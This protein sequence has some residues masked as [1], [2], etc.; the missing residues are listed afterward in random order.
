MGEVAKPLLFEGFHVGGYIVLFGTRRILWYSSFLDNVSKVLKLE[1]ISY[2]M[3]V[4]L[5]LRVSFRVSGFFVA[6]PYLW[7][8]VQFFFFEG[9]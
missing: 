6:L 3:F 5:L 2:E 8:K 4:L 7:G 1:E 9:F